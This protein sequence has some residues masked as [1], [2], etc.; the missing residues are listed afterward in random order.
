[1]TALHLLTTDAAPAHERVGYWGDLVQRS[2]GRLRSQTFGDERFRGEIRGFQLGA[3][4]L[5][6]LE[7]SRHRVERTSG[8]AG[9]SDP[10]DLKMVV[11]R[12]GCS[13]FEQDGRRAWLAPGSWSVYDTTRS[14]SV[15]NPQDV[16]QYVLLL[17]RARILDGAP[18]LRA[19]LVRPL[20]GARGMGRVLCESIARA[21]EDGTDELG[22]T[23]LR[24]V[25]Q[26]L[27]EQCGGLPAAGARALLRER[28][29]AL[30][31]QRLRDPS[32]DIDAMAAALG[33]S[34]RALHKAYEDR[35]ASLHRTLW[36]SRLEIARR[37]LEDPRQA[38]RSITSILLDAGFSSAAHFSRMFRLHYGA[39]PRDW[40]AGARV[41]VV[42]GR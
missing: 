1:M 37:Q 13:V 2:F 10:G 35:G 7:A 21:L 22:E 15:S 38:A 29:A 8:A 24:Q 23:I 18:E 36:R 26:A 31:C 32:L 16:L 33:C 17:P 42:G 41:P 34:K 40:R 20:S 19:L 27:L 14:Y 28:T 9:L 11:Q 25:R 30:I 4:R 12:R 3:L 39:S 6:R 5:C